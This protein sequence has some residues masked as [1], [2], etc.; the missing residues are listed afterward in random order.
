MMV[1]H[2]VRAG[3][4]VMH[5]TGEKIAEVSAQRPG[6]QRWSELVLYKTINDEFI[7]QKIGKT[8]VAHDPECRM[9]NHRMRSWL[10]ARDE[11]KIHRTPCLECNPTV[12]DLM[13]PHTR[14]EVQRYTV[15]ACAT[16]QDVVDTLTEGRKDLPT[17]VRILLED[18]SAALAV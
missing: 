11:G 7:L 1:D 10:E 8:T 12:G 18:A 17:L 4:R 13:D 15:Y 3:N 5:F 2:S 16:F 14:L 6:V 9:V